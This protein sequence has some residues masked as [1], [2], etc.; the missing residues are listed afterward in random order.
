M[1][2]ADPLEAAGAYAAALA[3]WRGP[4][5]GDLAAHDGLRAE[6]VRLDEL[7]LTVTEEWVECR[8]AAGGDAA[9]VGDL[10]GLTA[11]H[12]LR[13]RFWRQLMVALY[14]NGRQAD[15]L[16]RAGELRS[17]LRDE[18]GLNVSAALRELEQQVLTDHPGL[19]VAGR[20]SPVARR[21][22]GGRRPERVGR[23]R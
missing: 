3:W 23:A 11:L 13:E 21:G 17:H 9:L 20:P 10:E 2:I 18:L 6:A 22:T 1:E 15:A 8:L 14:R 19:L 12:P 16:R 4:P 5:F 7:R